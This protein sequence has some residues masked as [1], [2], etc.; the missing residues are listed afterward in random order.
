MKTKT[1]FVVF[2]I[3]RSILELMHGN[4]NLEILVYQTL[5]SS[6]CRP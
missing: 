3:T 4:W 2:S 6:D 1:F 5:L